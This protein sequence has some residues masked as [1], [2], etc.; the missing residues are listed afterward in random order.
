MVFVF[1]VLLLRHL[2][3]GAQKL[4]VEGGPFSL[5]KPRPGLKLPPLVKLLGIYRAAS[6]SRR[7]FLKSLSSCAKNR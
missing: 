3:T 6:V 5:R 1:L 7:T 4:G 2:V